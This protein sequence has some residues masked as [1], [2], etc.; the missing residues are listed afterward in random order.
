MERKHY[1][2][3]VEMIRQGQDGTHMY[4]LEKGQVNVSKVYV[5]VTLRKPIFFRTQF[6]FCN[7]FVS[8]MFSNSIFLNEI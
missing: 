4:I 6:V 2:A 3:K 7:F 5:Y 8:K 1:Q